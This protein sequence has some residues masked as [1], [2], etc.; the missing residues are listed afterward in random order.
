[1][2]HFHLSGYVNKQNYC[3][4]APKNPQELHPASSPLLYIVW[5]G[6][7]SF[8]VPGPYFFEDNESAVVTMTA[9]CCVEMLC[10]FCE[11]E[12]RHRGIDPSLVWFQQDGG[13]Q[14]IQQ[15]YQWVFCEKCFH[16]TSFLVAV[17]FH[18][19]CV[20]LISLPVIT[21]YGGI[22]K[23]RLSSLSLEPSGNWS[24]EYRKKLQQSWSRWLV[25]WWKIVEKVWSSVWGGAGLWMTKFSKIKW[26]VLSSSVIITVA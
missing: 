23:V 6:I 21:Y 10:N 26:H 22:S 12:L 11:P 1:M 2:L 16:N 4:W 7:A 14:P 17:M 3:C 18:G 9:E 20:H 8:G 19:L 13:Q 15:G 25:K 24:R 5:C